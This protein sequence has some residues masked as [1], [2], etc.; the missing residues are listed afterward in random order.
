[1]RFLWQTFFNSQLDKMDDSK[2]KNDEDLRVARLE[3]KVNV[4]LA[5][6]VLQS[7]V[8]FFMFVSSIIPSAATLVV[9]VVLAIIAVFLLNS[10][11]PGW[12]SFVGRMIRSTVR[13][14]Q[15]ATRQ[16]KD[17]VKEDF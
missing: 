7:V 3:S 15:S 2:F 10:Y 17:P 16:T 1:M 4:L 13:S 6:V 9:M 12:A 14:F 8:L 5:L 11:V